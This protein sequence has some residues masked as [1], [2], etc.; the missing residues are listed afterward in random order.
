MV[1]PKKYFSLQTMRAKIR[2]E[3]SQ[4]FGVAKQRYPV[5]AESAQAVRFL[6]QFDS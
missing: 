3:S 4:H 2:L 5:A 6:Q 1:A